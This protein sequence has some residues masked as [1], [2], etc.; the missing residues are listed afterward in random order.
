[1]IKNSIY[2]I[3]VFDIDLQ[4]SPDGQLILRRSSES[5]STSTG[6]AGSNPGPKG[7]GGSQQNSSS[8]SSRNELANNK[9]PW[10]PY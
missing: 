2:P 9:I 1:M 10:K 7:A 6:P 8:S 5:G 4:H 3:K